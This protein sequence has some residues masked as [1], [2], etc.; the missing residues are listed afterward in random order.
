MSRLWL[1]L[2]LLMLPRACCARPSSNLRV[3]TAANDAEATSSDD[4]RYIR[5]SGADVSGFPPPNAAANHRSP[6]P[7][8]NSL[9]NHGYLPRDGKA[10]TPELIRDAIVDVFNVDETLAERLTRPLPQQLTLADLSVHGFIEHDASLVH[11]DTFFK[12]DPAQI[13]A[14][15][16]DGLFAKSKDG[17]QDKHSM[18][19]ERRQREAQSKQENPEYALPLKAQAA[20]YGESALLLIAMG[21]YDAETISVEHA[22]SFLV[23]EK[24]PDGFRKSDKP[25]STAAAFYLA[26]QIKLLASLGWG[27]AVE[28]E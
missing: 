2:V 6:C 24:I 3:H 28:K 12:R 5:P 26:A 23:D 8:L 16:A 20:A 22:R 27:A 21:D 19:A 9:A 25:I 14:T 11:D 10:L 7:A 15:L 13:N 4:H 18:A 17:K 1:L